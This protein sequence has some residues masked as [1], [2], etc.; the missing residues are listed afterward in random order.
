MYAKCIASRPV[1]YQLRN[2]KSLSFCFRGGMEWKRRV[3]FSKLKSL[4]VISVLALMEQVPE[5]IPE[6]RRVFSVTRDCL[7]FVQRRQHIP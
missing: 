6:K 4:A 1:E 3:G 2:I 5:I 7:I